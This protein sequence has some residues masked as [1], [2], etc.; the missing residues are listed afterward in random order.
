MVQIWNVPPSGTDRAGLV[1]KTTIP[2]ALESLRTLH[3]GTDLPTETAP[4]MLA[5]R[6]ADGLIYQRNAGDSAWYVLGCAG[7]IGR[8]SVRAEFLSLSAT[9]VRRLVAPMG[10]MIV[11]RL[12]LISDTLSSSSSGNEW[13]VDVYNATQA[14]SLFSGV[15]GT[16]SSTPGIGGG[17][18]LAVDVAWP[19]TPDQNLA[20]AP[21]DV[22]RVA[23]TAVGTV[24]PIG[25]L[26]AVIEGYAAA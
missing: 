6:E 19:L 1:I 13:Q 14:V 3:N 24:T 2:N 21:N 23:M 8:H 17:A 9:A 16:Y 11:E 5:V 15:V 12:V 22:L 26:T 10:G 7:R 20:L 25:E 4:R 18:E